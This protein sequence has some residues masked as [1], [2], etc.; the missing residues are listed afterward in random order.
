MFPGPL[1]GGYLV[2]ITDNW[3]WTQYISAIVMGAIFIFGLGQS[4]TYQREIPRR[5]ARYQGKS[6]RQFILTQ[7]PAQSGVTIGEMLRITV[8]DP[9][10]M[11]FTEPIVILSTLFLL[12]NFAVVFQ[13]FISV[14]AA[15]GAPAPMGP[16]FTI[17]RIGLAIALTGIVG[18]SLAAL[19]SILIEQVSTGMLMKMLSMPSMPA[20]M[21]I[22]YRLVPAMIGQF[23]ITASLF[24]IGFTV[25]PQFQPTVPIIGTAFYIFGNASIIISIV[26]YLFDAF[27]PAGTL[28][29]L[30]SAASARLLFAGALPMV[31][32]Y[33]IT[34]LTPKWAFGIFGFISIAMWPIPFLLFRYGAVWREKSRYARVPSHEGTTIHRRLP[35]HDEEMT[36]Y[37]RASMSA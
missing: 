9:I 2:K 15:L 32:L 18:S 33:D 4:E 37:D 14:P 16:G 11:T 34:G 3:R 8:V 21:T 27:P 17:D 28:A 6:R 29:A 7:D 10:R 22:E 19:M 25:N 13:W 36:A 12:F 30:T 23:L 24:W 31:I 26:P 1:A 5:R 20:T 35:S